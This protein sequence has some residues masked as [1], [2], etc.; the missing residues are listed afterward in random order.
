MSDYDTLKECLLDR[1][2]RMANLYYVRDKS[3]DKVKFERW[4]AQRQYAQ[5]SW[6]LNLAV[7]A[8]Q[9]GLSTEIEL[10]MLDT[11][12]FNSNTRCG[13]IDRTMPDAKKKLAIVQ[14]AYDNLPETLRLAIP[15]KKANT[16]EIEWENGSSISVGTSHRGGTLQILH[17]SEF[18]PVSAE[19]PDR[20]REIITGGFNTVHVGQMVH[21]ESTSAGTGGE[22]YSMVQKAE[23]QQK[24]K[25][26]LGELD[27][28]LHFFPWWKEKGYRLNPNGVLVTAP[29]AEYFEGLE[30]LGVQL[31]PAQR[32]FYIGKYN[33]LGPDDVLK[34]YPSTIEECFK[35]SVEG[36]Y[37]KREMLKMRTDGRIG[38]MPHDPSRKVNTLW[39]I[40][41]ADP[42]FI[43]F[44]QTDGVRH[45]IID[46]YEASGEQLAHCITVLREKREKYGYEYDKHFGP[47]D[48]EHVDWSTDGNKTRAAIAADKGIKFTVVPRVLEIGDAIES[49]RRFLN[50]TWIDESKGARVIQCLDNYRREWDEQRGLWR[51][52]PRHDWASHGASALM[53]GAMGY[54]PER[55]PMRR[56]KE[57][58]GGGSAWAA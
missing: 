25:R 41:H 37:F 54:E 11:C 36:A 28:K 23:A 29:L 6:F 50:L 43:I 1:E 14:F 18:G 51:N 4:E 47:H 46:C 53:Q 40:G 31:D 3:G 44:H 42:N 7:K 48:L 39:D 20:A 58:V 8:R 21:V 35:S 10:E 49:A 57:K 32:A 38:H 16:E 56:S 17:V 26:E 22:F 30:K 15:T 5:D 34:E 24:E 9:L 33:L 13:I 2:W 19:S 55:V 12:L 52:Q 27:F 45:R